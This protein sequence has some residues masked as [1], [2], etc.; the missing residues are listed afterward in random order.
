MEADEWERT[1]CGEIKK[2]E[3]LLGREICVSSSVYAVSFLPLWRF[4]LEP[5]SF[6][7]ASFASACLGG[8]EDGVCF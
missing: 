2:R 8:L 3:A 5:F 4:S 1:A 7:D 6:F